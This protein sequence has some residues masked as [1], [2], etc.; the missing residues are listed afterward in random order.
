MTVLQEPQHVAYGG[1]T[2][3]DVDAI[4]D[5]VARGEVVARLVVHGP[6]APAPDPRQ[7][8]PREGA[9]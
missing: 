3:D 4:A 9:T 8:L 5:A 1:V 6:D 2:L 7:E